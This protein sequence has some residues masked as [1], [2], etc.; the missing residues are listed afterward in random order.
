MRRAY[1]FSLCLPSSLNSIVSR[2][3]GYVRSGLRL[4]RRY[5]GDRQTCEADHRCPTQHRG[6]NRA[7]KDYL[8]LAGHGPI[9]VYGVDHRG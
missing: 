2:R 9:H 4:L 8:D 5:S 6:F 1:L 7:S 3:H